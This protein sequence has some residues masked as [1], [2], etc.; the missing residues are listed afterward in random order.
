MVI[1]PRLVP[2]LAPRTVAENSVPFFLMLDKDTVKERC[3]E[4]LYNHTVSGISVGF[5]G[6][7]ERKSPWL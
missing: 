7:V 3:L 4:V 1:I 6:V 2:L 5:S